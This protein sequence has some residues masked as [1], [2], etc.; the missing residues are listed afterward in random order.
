MTKRAYI[1]TLVFVFITSYAY[2]AEQTDTEKLIRQIS[3]PLSVLKEKEV[4]KDEIYLDCYYE[5]S[6]IL[7]GSKTGQWSELTTLF[8]YLHGNVRGY[9]SVSQYERFDNKDYTGNIGAYFTFKDSYVHV[10]EGFGWMVDYMY[11]FQ[12]IA[13]YGHKLVDTLFGQ[14]GYSYRGYPSGD[15]HV[16]YPSLIY[17]FGDSYMSATYGASYIEARD[18]A[19]FGTIQ[20]NFAITKFLQWYCGLAFGGRLYDIYGLDAHDEY[21]YILFTGIKLNIYKGIYFRAGYSYGTEKPKF[22]KR[23]VNFGLSVKF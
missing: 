22:I 16:V 13:E 17:Y 4:V 12:S 6:E 14:I 5:P 1:A 2:S 10:E 11:K 20:G 8:A 7:Q 18:T 9:A 21:G 3:P 15:T 23:S 19:S